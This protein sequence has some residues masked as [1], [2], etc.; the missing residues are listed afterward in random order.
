MRML[1]FA[2]IGAI[3]LAGCAGDEASPG[4]ES[5]WE[6]ADG[7]GYIDAVEAKYG[8]DPFNATSVP[9]VMKHMDIS[10]DATVRNVVGTGV[11]SIQCPADQVNSQSVIWTILA[12]EGNVSDPHAANLVITITGTATLNDADL[13]IY[14][15]ETGL[16]G[17]AIG[18]TASETVTLNG[19]HPIGD[20]TI[21]V[22]GCSGIGDVTV[23]GTGMVGWNPSMA[24]LLSD[25]HDDDGHQ[26]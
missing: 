1:M 7:D 11:P 6:D 3:A 26:H 22:R 8:T 9:D 2:L 19:H 24:D 21:E 13:F 18:S 5:S 15:P 25:A 17:S 10:F 23:A 20:Y 12:P 16:L 14:G 4:L